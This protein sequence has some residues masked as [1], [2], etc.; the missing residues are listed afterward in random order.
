[1]KLTTTYLDSWS[2]SSSTTTSNI[3]YKDTFFERANL[4]PIRGEPTFE[5]LH[6]IW[7]EI[8]ENAQAVY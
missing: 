2:E 7:N 8:K 1:M 4:T 6:N 5:A 3:N